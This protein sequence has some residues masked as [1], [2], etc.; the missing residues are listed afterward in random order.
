[1]NE[2]FLKEKFYAFTTNG[3][4][5]AA[6]MEK[7]LKQ[8]KFKVSRKTITFLSDAKVIKRP[9]DNGQKGHGRRTLYDF[10]AFV[11]TLIYCIVCDT[12]AGLG[13]G[14][15]PF[16]KAM[17]LSEVKLLC[18]IGDME[19]EKF[20]NYAKVSVLLSGN[21]ANPKNVPLSKQVESQGA[22]RC[23]MYRTAL[24]YK[25]LQVLFKDNDGGKCLEVWEI[26]RKFLKKVPKLYSKCFTKHLLDSECL[27]NDVSIDVIKTRLEGADVKA[28]YDLK[29]WSEMVSYLDNNSNVI[30]KMAARYMR[31]RY[32]LEVFNTS[33]DWL[34]AFN[35]MRMI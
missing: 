17:L 33:N 34:F 29:L 25:L 4:L 35:L 7:L 8:L 19:P 3:T 5:S 21:K 11:D 14:S 13:K 16:D 23:L 31:K 20:V 12:V 27:A 30:S 10:E 9:L 2:N 32:G 22:V 15:I 26:F 24:L 18:D 28:K 6:Q 1:M